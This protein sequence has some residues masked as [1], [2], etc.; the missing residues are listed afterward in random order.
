MCGIAG[1]LASV[2]AARSDGE[3]HGSSDT[4]LSSYQLDLNLQTIND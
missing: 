4:R 1:H 2:E 3:L